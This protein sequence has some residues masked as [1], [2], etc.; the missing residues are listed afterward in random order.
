MPVS[1]EKLNEAFADATEEDVTLYY[2][3]FIKVAEQYEI[4]TPERMAAFIAQIAHES[5]NLR[6][7]KENLNYSAQGLLKVFPKYFTPQSAASYARNPEKIANKVYA[8]RMGN[9]PEE[10]GDG[11]RYRGRGLIQLTGKENHTNFANDMGMTLDESLEYLDTPEGAMMSAGW[12]WNKR[13]LND[14]AD[15]G[16][17]KGISKRVNGGTIGLQERI[18]NYELALEVLR[19]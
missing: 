10:S 3:P 9:G 12:F 15:R 16:D 1:L 4:N 18:D 6:A 17:I 13:H 5:M 19:G 14:Y 7:T 2:E 8:N 11:W